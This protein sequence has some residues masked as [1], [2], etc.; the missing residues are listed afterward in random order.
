M[1]S[2]ELVVN[3]G[4]ALTSLIVL[5]IIGELIFRL[6][7]IQARTGG[8]WPKLQQWMDYVWYNER[9]SL[10]FRDREHSY[11]KP[12]DTY[13]ILILGDSIV[14]GQMVEYKEI[15][16]VQLEQKIAAA[17][18]KKIEVISMGLMGWNTM[19]QLQALAAYG[20]RF[21]PDLVL[22]GFS[23]NDPQVKLNPQ[24]RETA[25]AERALPFFTSIDPWLNEHSYFYSF[26]RFRYNRLLEKIGWKNDYWQWQ[27]TLYQQNSRGWQDYK[28]SLEQI[29]NLSRK[30]R[31]EV[32]FISLFYKPG[33]ES[34]TAQVLDLA[35]ELN[36]KALDMMPYFDEF[37]FNELIVSASDWHPNAKTH[38]IY[39]QV[40]TEFIINKVSG[41]R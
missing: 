15:F 32:L 35:D 36:I 20:L 27:K 18:K 1:K 30:N 5:A 6:P 22:I 40:L 9:N 17:T 23:L 10:G 4:V 13:R 33:W 3:I 12:E 39:A 28:Y 37:N 29:N 11:V 34:E 21:Q 38:Q 25:D 16:P 26:V 2:K 31:S 19:E 41:I 8:N 7:Q 24:S 14:Y